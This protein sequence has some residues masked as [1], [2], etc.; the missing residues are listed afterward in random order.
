MQRESHSPQNRKRRLKN[1]WSTYSGKTSWKKEPSSYGYKKC[2]IEF[3]N[4]KVKQDKKRVYN[5]RISCPNTP[6]IFSYLVSTKGLEL[7][8]CLSLAVTLSVFISL[9]F[10][11]YH[12]RYIILIKYLLSS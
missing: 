6:Q 2:C 11:L 4:K 9:L 10:S 8:T 7:I 1:M 12:I 5:P 3:T